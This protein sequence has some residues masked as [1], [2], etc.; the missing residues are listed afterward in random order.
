MRLWALL[1]ALV[2][3]LVW[4][5]T[6]TQTR[7][8]FFDTDPRVC[9]RVL[10]G[11]YPAISLDG[12]IDPSTCLEIIRDAEAHAV[13]KG[14]WDTSRHS[15]YPT[16]DFDTADIPSL[17]YPIQNIVYT[18]VIPRM[19]AAYGLDPLKLGIDEVF[20]AKY[21]AA[22]GRQHSLATHEDGSDFSF[23]IAL[24]DEYSGGGT[25]FERTGRVVKSARGSA[26]GFCG[27]SRH[28]GLRTTG[29]T[30]YILAG[31]LKYETPEGCG[32]G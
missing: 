20:I 31:F 15:D 9:R 24:N 22:E 7:E 6:Q 12:V 13:D 27:K 14:G 30:R 21:E 8:G 3:A 10:A 11:T 29:G 2:A 26:V 32:D 1:G 17:T 28:Q 19:V 4:L 5:A 18:R 16:T 23:V 25:K